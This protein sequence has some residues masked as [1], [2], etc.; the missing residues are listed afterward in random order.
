MLRALLVYGIASSVILGVFFIFVIAGWPGPVSDCI[1]ETPNDGCFCESFDIN[2]VR[3]NEGGIRQLTNTLSN[4][5][6]LGTALIVALVLGRD[7]KIF[8]GRAAPNI[9]RSSS[10]IADIYLFA[11][12]FLGLG[13][14]WFHASMKAWGSTFDGLSM[15]IYAAF[16]VFYTMIR[17]YGD[18]LIFYIGYPTVVVTMT[19][20]HATGVPSFALIII[21]VVFYLLLEVRLWFHQ[22][23]FAM[24]RVRPITLWIGAALSMGWATAFWKLSQS[25]GAMCDPDSWF[26]PHGLLWHTLAGVMALL[27]FFYWREEE[28]GEPVLYDRRTGPP[29]QG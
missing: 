29:H 23:S 14:M 15:Y 3:Q 17:L 10:I 21:L 7:R 25:G 12:L 1:N 22:G 11:V 9:M 24:G 8:A 27:L 4:L 20:F 18:R 5:Y 26:Q 6:S 19:L 2:K 28:A 13:S 16:L